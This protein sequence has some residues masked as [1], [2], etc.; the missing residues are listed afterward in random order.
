MDLL[1]GSGAKVPIAA[2]CLLIVVAD[3]SVVE[4]RILY[5]TRALDWRLI[6]DWCP[7]MIVGRM[8]INADG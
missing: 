4:S 8:K 3:Y 2:V 6:F 5:L 1:T 7:N